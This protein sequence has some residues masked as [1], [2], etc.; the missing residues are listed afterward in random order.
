MAL[1]CYGVVAALLCATAPLLSGCQTIYSPARDKQGQDAQKAWSEVDLASQVTVPRKNIKALLDEQLAMEDDIWSA[2]RTARARSMAHSWSLARLETEI[3]SRLKFLAG[4]MSAV[5]RKKNRDE[6]TR[7]MASL[8]SIAESNALAGQPPPNCAALQTGKGLAEAHAAAEKL[9]D[10]AKVTVA[11]NLDR[12]SRECRSVANIAAAGGAVGEAA[13]ILEADKA[14][15]A[16]DE[17]AAERLKNAYAT[18]RRTYDES[19]RT[20]L[21]DPSDPKAKEAVER[22][23][24]KLGNLV[25]AVK[26]AQDSFS[27][28]LIT[29]ERL[30]SLD[31]FLTTYKDVASGKGVE[32]GNKVAIA[33]AL[34]PDL[35]DKAR[36]A[37]RDLERPN[38]V[39]LAVQ[40]NI[41]LAKLE[42]AQRSID[43]RRQVV[44][45]RQAQVAALDAQVEALDEAKGTF[46]DAAVRDLLNK[47]L[48]EVM[49][50][51]SDKGLDT[52]VKLWRSTT[53]YLDAEG[54]LRAEAGKAPYRISALEHERAL[55]LAESN[56]NQWKAL[57]DPSVEL[58]AGYGAAGLKSSDLI[59]L[60]NSLTLLWIAIGV[61]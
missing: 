21:G 35:R 47:T 41:E 54:R 3:E 28:K 39:P 14:A 51:K 29:E 2:F 56:I 16:A 42:G 27:T 9:P 20:L 43:L 10:P 49:N 50:E 57:I 32:D 25:E 40:K 30:A 37:L 24:T 5:E 38:L 4:S 12:A 1:R 13:A 11:V 15:L 44:A 52:R 31:G 23:V 61:N 60:F 36:T 55:T 58:M 22:A 17:S 34:F 8:Q 33:L 59:A 18:A 48:L 6:L 19:A 46:K 45:E 26:S 7:A 53:R